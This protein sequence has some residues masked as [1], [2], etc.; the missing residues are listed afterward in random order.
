MKLDDC[1]GILEAGDGIS[2]NELYE[3][4]SQYLRPIPLEYKELLKMSNGI[5][6]ENGL[7]LYSSEDVLER[8]ATFEV[9][10]YAPGFFAIGDDSGGRSILI[11][12][13]ESGVFV[14]GQGSMD[15]TDMRKIGDSLSC[16]IDAG[17][18]I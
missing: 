14:V 10:K 6:F 4:E 1:V 17:C 15:P 18:V 5:V 12:L 8:N 11:H 13:D 16:W 2:V 9:E 3:L 7:V